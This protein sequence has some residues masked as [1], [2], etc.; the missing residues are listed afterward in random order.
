ME[1][2][3]L[4]PDDQRSWQ[5]YPVFEARVRAMIGQ[6][7]HEFGDQNRF[8]TELRQR[9]VT[10]PLLAGYWLAVEGE[11]AVAHVCGWVNESWGRPYVLCFQAE[12]D[13][14]WESRDVL[15]RVY[16]EAAV[17]VGEIN[18]ALRANK[19]DCPIIDYVEQWT[20]HKPEQWARAL[21]QLKQKTVLH[22]M[23]FSI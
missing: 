20:P 8:F 3:R 4:Q 2:I 1:L 22:V 16:E 18:K 6:F 5:L 11:C 10:T 12:C 19:A 23:R 14:M 9:W 7:C 13:R 17:W 15:P 21:P